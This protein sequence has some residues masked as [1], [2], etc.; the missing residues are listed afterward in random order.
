MLSLST[1][2]SSLDKLAVSGSAICAIH[3]L[4]L[5]LLVGVFP[6]L[7]ATML[8]QESFHVLLL[9][10]VVPLSIV[11]LSLGCQKHGDKLLALLGVS[12]LAALIVSAMLGHD[13]FGEGGERIGTLIGAGAIA[14][15][16]LRNYALCRVARCCPRPE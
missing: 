10:L 13:V 12:G 7:G 14:A 3:C 11:T 1:S 16:H 5:P 4:C 15:A 2:L 9:W 6:A 8:G